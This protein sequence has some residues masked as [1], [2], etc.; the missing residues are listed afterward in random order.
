MQQRAGKEAADEE[1][2][3]ELKRHGFGSCLLDRGAAEEARGR[4]RM[5]ENAKRTSKAFF[6]EVCSIT[7]STTTTNRSTDYR[8]KRRRGFSS[9]DRVTLPLFGNGALAPMLYRLAVDGQWPRVGGGFYTQDRARSPCRLFVCASESQLDTPR[10]ALFRGRT[11][12]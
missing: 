5:Q 4:R 10:F 2:V 12:R 7:T 9:I 11:G 8:A 1:E 3:E 6:L